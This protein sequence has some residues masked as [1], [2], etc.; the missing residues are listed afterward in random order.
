M[1]HWISARVKPID[2][3]TAPRIEFD[4]SPWGGG[5]AILF[6]GGL[7]T[8]FFATVWSDLVASKLN[9]SVGDPS[10]Q[11]TFELYTVLLALVV[12]AGRFKHDGMILMG[13]N[14]A[15]LDATLTLKGKGGMVAIVR[16]ISWRRTRYAWKYDVAHLPAEANVHADALSRSA[17]PDAKQLPLMLA[18]SL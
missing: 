11:T 4:A 3:E 6:E 18:N 5:G 13:D 14:L 10:G 16:E 1:E 8:E 2:R 12:W 17:A 15:A 7:P 9:A